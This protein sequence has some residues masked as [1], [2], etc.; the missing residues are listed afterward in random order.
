METMQSSPMSST[1]TPAE[2]E[3]FE[4]VID[5]PFD[6]PH[7]HRFPS[8]WFFGGPDGTDF[9]ADARWQPTAYYYFDDKLT[10]L[11][12]TSVPG[13]DDEA[14]DYFTTVASWGPGFVPKWIRYRRP[15]GD[16]GT[17]PVIYNKA[18]DEV[19]DT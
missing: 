19:F 7:E 15:N 17:R 12:T 16:T 10:I 8:D 9:R 1:T 4:W 11:H 13:C 3:D 2:D 5:C 18:T 14:I 6:P